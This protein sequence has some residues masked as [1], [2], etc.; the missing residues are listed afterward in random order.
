MTVFCCQMQRCDSTFILFVDIVT[1]LNNPLNG[2]SVSISG[3]A[4]GI[5]ARADKT[6]RR[7]QLIG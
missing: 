3:S 6:R 1:S 5:D 2:L 4:T 7:V